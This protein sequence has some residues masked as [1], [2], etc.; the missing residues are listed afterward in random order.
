MKTHI[1]FLLIFS[2]LFL[3]L[4]TNMVSAA[5]ITLSKNGNQFS[6][7]SGNYATATHCSGQVCNWLVENQAIVGAY[8]TNYLKWG[9]ILEYDFDLSKIKNIIK[10]D[11]V[12]EW[13]QYAGKGLHSPSKDGGGAIFVK[14]TSNKIKSYSLNVA[15]CPPA[16]DY[17]ANACNQ[18]SFTNSI[19]LKLITP[20]T[21]VY[22]KTNSKTA[23]DV[24]K[25]S[26]IITTSGGTP[27]CSSN[28][29]CGID[30]WVGILSC[31]SDDLFQAWRAFTCNNPGTSQ[32]SCS[33]V[34]I[35]KLKQDCGN[36]SYG[37]N[38]CYD[39]DVY[40][41]FTDRGC[42]LGACFVNTTKQKVQECGASGC[43][44]N[45]CVLAIACYKDSDCG[46][47]G[48]VGFTNCNNDDIFQN[49]RGYGCNLPGTSQ[50]Y[51]TSAEVSLLKQ[52]CGVDSC[53]AFGANYCKNNDVYHNQTC[54]DKGCNLGSCFTNTFVNEALVQ[55]C[56]ASGC[57]NGKC[58]SIIACTKNSD[59]GTDGYV[60]SPFC[61]GKNIVQNYL[62]FTCN[63][64]GT[65]QASCSNSSTQ[66][67]IQ[68][69]QDYCLNAVCKLFVCHNDSECNDNNPGTLDK[70]I[71]P[72]TIN[73]RCENTQANSITIENGKIKIN[74]QEFIVKGVDYA[75]WII[76]AGPEPY[77]QQKFPDEN[78]DITSKLTNNGNRYVTDYSGDGNIQTWEMIK[79]DVSIMKSAGINTIRTY[80]AG[81]WHDK[82]LNGVVDLSS[83]S[84]VNEIIQGDLPDW[85]IDR[86]LQYANENGMK[87]IIGYWI[88]EEDFKPGRIANFDDLLV[89]K[90]A[91]GR[92][93]NK[94]KS[95][96]AVLAW[97][98]GNEV[99]GNW[100]HAWFMWG[101]DIDQYLSQLND[102]VRTLDNKPIIYA[103][104]VGEYDYL[105]NLNVD[106][107]S[108]N[109]YTNSAPLLLSQ[110]NNLQAIPPGKACMYGEF[111]HTLS[112]ASAQWNEAKQY[113]GGAFLEYN[114]V[115]W[116]GDASLFGIVDAYR[117]IRS[118]RFDALKL[119]Y[120]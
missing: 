88:Q 26:L 72:G 92:V 17:F 94:Y 102:Y 112:Q 99:H 65:S 117:K 83:N 105:S 12:V 19:P 106:I 113:A 39:N 33:S 44:N 36:D 110:C 95:N 85:A 48:W 107:I 71:N 11:L 62:T 27:M 114:D 81:S 15:R 18:F 9:G 101:V 16:Y 86:I 74:N 115:W 69:C 43:S 6:A 21:K 34:D 20:I 57:S 87:V 5:T 90:Q 24:S 77:V 79:Y 25:V 111:G 61:S 75:P 23:W 78:E 60:G 7:A 56:G 4:I 49:W 13:P 32:S 40:R 84:D 80:A 41:D 73:A 52:D 104:Y 37:S 28:S 30:G 82:N 3:F 14:S 118:D 108:V 109:A 51:C 98:I 45:Q 63:N 22:L 119:L 59:C 91:F 29:D 89:A 2:L 1:F 103:K 55:D 97:G 38:Y 35:S 76:T 10:V 100:N 66:K 50:A 68:T 67:T 47:P 64:P 8:N 46:T 120:S 42:S 116:K 96:P 70:C 58:N 31:N 93:V 54:Y 53:N